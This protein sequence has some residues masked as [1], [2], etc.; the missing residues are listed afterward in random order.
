M[1][2]DD[3]SALIDPQTASG[4]LGVSVDV[5]AQWR[6]RDLGPAYYQV[7]P[8]LIRYRRGEV[9]AWLEARKTVPSNAAEPA[10]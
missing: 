3:D 4:L 5:L 7:G 6:A 2:D 10:A 8:K 1:S 9:V